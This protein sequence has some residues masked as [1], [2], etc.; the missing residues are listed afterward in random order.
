[1][2]HSARQDI[3]AGDVVDR[4]VRASR[5]PFAPSRSASPAAVSSETCRAQLPAE[6]PFDLWR[7]KVVFPERFAALLKVHFNNDAI[8]IAYSFGV[9][10]KAAQAW[11]AG[12]NVPNG[13]TAV[14]AVATI[15][16]AV[17]FLMDAG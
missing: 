9:S 2:T 16:G 4:S 10:E 8:A 3:F 17:A 15:P 7:Y 12:R 1:M 13:P 6:R 5:T 14:L 11:L